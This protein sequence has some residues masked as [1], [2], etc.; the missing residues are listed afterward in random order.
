MGTPPQ[1]FRAH[2]DI[3]QSNFFVPSINCTNQTR[4]HEV[5]YCLYHLMYSSV[6]SST[7]E[8]DLTPARLHYYGVY[9][10]GNLSKDIVHIGG[11][12]V[13]QQIFQEAIMWHPAYL[14]DWDEQYDTVLGLARLREINTYDDFD[15]PG[16]VE[17]M[18][19]QNTLD[20]NVFA[21]RLPRTDTEEGL[22]ILG[23]VDDAMAGSVIRIPLV[24]VPLDS[25]DSNFVPYASAGWVV[26]TS[27]L[28]LDAY[29]DQDPLTVPLPG[30]VAVLSNGYTGM[31]FPFAIKK[32]I[33]SYLQWD[34][35]LDDFP[36]EQRNRF[37]N[38]TIA[39]GP[40]DYLLVLSPWQYMHEVING[41]GE[42]RC[43][44]PFHALYEDAPHPDYILLGAAFMAG[45]YTE[46]D[47][48]AKTIGCKY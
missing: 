37:P 1:P 21:L 5:E 29:L 15:V 16:L 20:R 26:N 25:D 33:A 2:I 19:E 18:V 45:L 38:F 48:G 9:T 10:R 24:D 36:C 30:Y 13:K 12:S 22:L 28:V 6:S 40:Q 34:D 35:W 17:N 23:G 42:Q 46:F 8:P 41:E 47:L 7:Y 11:V 4:H 27:S 44:L 31:M 14:I 3:T 39:L 43:L 32:R